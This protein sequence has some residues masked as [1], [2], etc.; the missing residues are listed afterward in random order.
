MLVDL[1]PLPAFLVASVVVVLTPGVDV[2][3]LLRTSLNRGRRA[4]MLALAGIHTA[5]IL[6]VALVISGLG[7]L[8]TKHPAVLSAL[9]WIGA[10]YLV[11][12]AVSILRGLWLTRKKS[13]EGTLS[14]PPVDNSNPYLRGLFSNLTNPKML[15]FSLAF[16][17]QFVGSAAQ[18]ALQ[19]VMLGVVFLVL[20]LIWEASMVLGAAKIADR[21]QNPRV[22]KS[23]D[24]VSAAA[25]LTISVGLVAG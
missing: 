24:V 11:Y 16:L 1:T 19:L 2:F 17:P 15:L 22:A 13:V 21:L 4:G 25:F 10:A 8:V 20:A 3:L 14:G 12:L 7:A 9:K 18:P 23:L 5:S 6:Q